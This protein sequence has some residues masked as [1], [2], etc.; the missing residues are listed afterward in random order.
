MAKLYSS[1][2]FNQ[3]EGLKASILEHYSGKV[4]ILY[5]VLC[6]TGNDEWGKK[7][8]VSLISLFCL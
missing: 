7:E 6:F 2:I 3:S 1:K 4:L 5:L 8:N